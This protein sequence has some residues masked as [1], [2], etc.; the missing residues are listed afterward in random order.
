MASIVE[1]QRTEKS[2]DS[3][4]RLLVRLQH[5][6]RGQ[7]EFVVERIGAD[8][9]RYDDLAPG[10]FVCPNP[11]AE[12]RIE[13]Q[14]VGLS[15]RLDA[16]SAR[17]G[18]A[19]GKMPSWCASVLAWL[20]RRK[21]ED[22]DL[23][24]CLCSADA[25]RVIYPASWKPSRARK[26]WKHLMRAGRRTHLIGLGLS[27]GLI[28]PSL[29]LALLPGPNVL[30]FWFSYRSVSHAL[31]WLGAGRVIKGGL[32]VALQADAEPRPEA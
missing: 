22:E 15:R 31:S 11:K 25:V 26:K 4:V 29:I 17:M 3:H 1:E 19:Q 12:G 2:P 32:P 7:P 6:K 8:D 16:I 5:R 21:P 30:G 14:I 9:P 18:S 28:P 13:R 20:Q 10:G 27:L 23:M 24:R